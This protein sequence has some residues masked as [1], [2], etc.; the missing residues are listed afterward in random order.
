MGR[1]ITGLEKVIQ[2]AK[3]DYKLILNYLEAYLASNIIKD[4]SAHS[5]ILGECEKI[6]KKDNKID[7]IGFC[8]NIV[9]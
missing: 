5:Y 4:N 7:L 1:N 9:S 2:Q 8:N 6:N 3:N